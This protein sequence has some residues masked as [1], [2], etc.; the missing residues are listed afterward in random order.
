MRD[1][2]REDVYS[3]T[4]IAPPM[5][6]SRSEVLKLVRK[7]H[8]DLSQDVCEGT[9]NS[10]LLFRSQKKAKGRPEGR[11]GGR[12]IHFEQGNGYGLLSFLA[13]LNRTAVD[14]PPY[15]SPRALFYYSI[16]W[17]RGTFL[18]RYSSFP[19]FQRRRLWI[20]RLLL[21][22]PIDSAYLE[23]FVSSPKLFYQHVIPEYIPSY[24]ILSEPALD[25]L[26]SQ[27]TK[28]LIPITTRLL[29][30]TD[31]A[32]SEKLRPDEIKGLLDKDFSEDRIDEYLLLEGKRLGIPTLRFHYYY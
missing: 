18:M 5:A 3:P 11:P 23:L 4:T 14:I 6:L 24:R 1:M 2:Y 9:G 29:R 20:Q 16:S 8:L 7:P 19:E 26:W 30:L 12:I 21:L 32:R 28:P 27:Q 22:Y 10:S 17:Y 25:R 13:L 31:D 15:L